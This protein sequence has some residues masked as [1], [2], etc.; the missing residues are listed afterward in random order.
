MSLPLPS[1]QTKLNPGILFW[2]ISLLSI[3]VVT[4]G[5][6]CTKKKPGAQRTTSGSVSVGRE[7]VML[8]SF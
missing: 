5:G 6:G 3:V 1:K 2:L 4:T 8:S 7:Q